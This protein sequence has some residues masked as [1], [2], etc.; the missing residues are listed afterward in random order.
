[1]NT[2]VV[3]SSEFLVFLDDMKDSL[4]LNVYS[5]LFSDGKEKDY[6]FRREES[7]F[8]GLNTRGNIKEVM[9]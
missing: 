5:R 7:R 6:C 9:R 1:M 2:L 8:I 3:M 4:L